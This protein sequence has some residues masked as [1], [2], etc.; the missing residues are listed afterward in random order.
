VKKPIGLASFH[1]YS[2]DIV[3]VRIGKR[4]ES[5][6]VYVDLLRAH[7]LYFCSKYS[8]NPFLAKNSLWL[9]EITPKTFKHFLS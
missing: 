2:Q 3:V 7:S 1:D 4:T 8:K 5:F 9:D 6:N